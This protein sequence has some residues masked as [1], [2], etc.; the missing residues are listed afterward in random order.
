MYILDTDA[1]SELRKTKAGKGNPNVVA[2]VESVEPVDTSLSSITIHELELG[3]LL[4]ERRDPKQGAILR[5]WFETRL[6]PEFDERTFAID[7]AVARRC[8]AL[9]VPDP[10]PL[11]DSF[12]AATALVHGVIVVTRNADDCRPMGA[13]AL[14]P[15]E[16][17]P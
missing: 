16:S 14:N 2:W 13:E 5:T 1:V 6:L 3:T 7:L 9:H 8:A 15:W 17:E 12:V 10:R 11:R 4:L